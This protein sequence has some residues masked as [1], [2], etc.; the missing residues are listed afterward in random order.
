MYLV[1]SNSVII[2]Y[3]GYHFYLLQ[4]AAKSCRGRQKKYPTF[5][6]LKKKKGHI[7]SVGAEKVFAGGGG[8]GGG[9]GGTQVRFA[10]ASDLYFL[11]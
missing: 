3:L 5:F 1:T 11:E 7:K 4:G 9:G 6:P 10:T 2:H 8:G